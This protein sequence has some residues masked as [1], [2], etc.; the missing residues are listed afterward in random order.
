MGKSLAGKNKRRQAAAARNLAEGMSTEEALVDAGYSPVTARKNG[1]AIVRE[2]YIQSI[3]TESCQR[4]MYKRQMDFDGI[5]EPLFDALNAKIILK[6]PRRGKAIQTNVVDHMTRMEA[7]GRLIDLHRR[8]KGGA[9][10]DDEKPPVKPL[11]INVHFIDPPKK[12]APQPVLLAPPNSDSSRSSPD[13]AP[14]V[15]QAKFVSGKD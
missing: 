7:A 14:P 15:P 1:Y 2:P 5:L 12:Q 13:A 6:V 10:E 3:L 11:I 9:V 8:N 4:I